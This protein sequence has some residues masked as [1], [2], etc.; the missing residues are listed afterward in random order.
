MKYFLKI[1]IEANK[2]FLKEF[3]TI[4]Q[5]CFFFVLLALPLN[6]AF[7]LAG[8][9]REVIF[10]IKGLKKFNQLKN[11][12]YFFHFDDN[13]KKHG[14]L[15]EYYL[16]LPNKQ[17]FHLK[18]TPDNQIE[19]LSNKKIIKDDLKKDHKELY[20]FVKLTENKVSLEEIMDT[21][22]THN[23][24]KIKQAILANQIEQERNDIEVLLSQPLKIEAKRLKI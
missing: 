10:L 11:T 9:P 21:L 17:F 3:N 22:K 1:E 20:R 16:M 14:S 2:I 19:I 4:A 5:Q 23:T 18:I 13:P 24:D 8:F 6:L 12:E 7:W 15:D